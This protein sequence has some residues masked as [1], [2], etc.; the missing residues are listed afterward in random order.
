MTQ[1]IHPYVYAGCLTKGDILK[2]LE[3]NRLRDKVKLEEKR[4]VE[5]SSKD[6]I[7][8]ACLEDFKFTF[9]RITKRN[10]KRTG[11][12]DR[13]RR[14]YACRS[15]IYYFLWFKAGISLCDISE[16]FTGKREHTT[17]RAAIHDAKEKIEVKDPVIYP[18]YLRICLK[19]NY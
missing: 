8:N 19:L 2:A 18:A 6:D 4:T 7:I 10:M 9:A 13:S 15:L 3:L 12:L 16:L 5:N 14:V 17:P 1:L 11:K